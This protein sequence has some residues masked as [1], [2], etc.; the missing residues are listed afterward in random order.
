[1]HCALIQC[2]IPQKKFAC[3]DGEKIRTDTFL[4][5]STRKDA[6]KVVFNKYA[7]AP[8]KDRGER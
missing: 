2:W 4:A 1:M 5:S 3:A 6:V 8:Q 7:W